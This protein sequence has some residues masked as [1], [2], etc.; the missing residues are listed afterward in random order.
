M[1]TSPAYLAFFKPQ[2]D[3]KEEG[4]WVVGEGRGEGDASGEISFRSFLRE[5]VMSSFCMGR[6]VHSLTLSIQHFVC[7]PSSVV[8]WAQSTN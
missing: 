6:D 7:R 3:N 5:A 2:R 1:N 8:D 4:G